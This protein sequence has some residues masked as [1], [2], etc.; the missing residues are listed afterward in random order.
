MKRLL[1]LIS[2]LLCSL[3]LKAQPYPPTF[4]G[5][6]VTGSLETVVEQL[7]AAGFVKSSTYM[8]YGKFKGLDVQAFI[9][10]SKTKQQVHG[11]LMNEL[12]GISD[13]DQAIK[14][15][16]ALVDDYTKDPDFTAAPENKKIPAGEDLRACMQNDKTY[17][18]KFYQKGDKKSHIEVSLKYYDQTFMIF[19]SYGN[20][21]A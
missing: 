15:F 1:L 14:K 2:V 21:H 20:R 9:N 12:A 7:E 4:L 6:Q 18:V 10:W 16:N 5:V 11:I 3:C 19:I 17:E 13:N 8:Y